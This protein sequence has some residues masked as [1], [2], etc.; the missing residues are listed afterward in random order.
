MKKP[1]TWTI[2]GSD[3][4]GGAGIQ[5]DLMTMNSLGVL[6][7]SVITALTAQNTLGIAEVEYPSQNMLAGQLGALKT[8]LPPVAVKIGML[9]HADN[10]ATIVRH[11]A[12]LD[13][14]LVCDP[15]VIA[16]SGR[17][18]LDPEALKKM[19]SSLLPLVDLLTP[20]LPEAEVLL[21]RQIT[22]AAEMESAA[23]ALLDLGVSSVL[24]KGG[25][26]PGEYCQDFWTNGSRRAWITSPK[27][28][29]THTHGTGCTLSSAIASARAL[30]F[31]ELDAI[32]IAKAYVNQGLRRGAD[33]GKGKG[34][35]AHEGWPAAPEDL[36]WITGAPAAEVARLVFPDCGADPI[37]L[38]PVVDR[39]D[40]IERLLPLG[41]RMIQLRLKDLAGAELEKEVEQAVS[42]ARR[43]DA[44][45]F[46]NDH[47]QAA[48]K[49]GAYGVH[50]GQEDLP[51]AD[52]AALSAAGLR[53]GA[54]ATSYAD[55]A[56]L[57][58]LKPSYV[59][60]GA[61]F[62]T[63]SKAIDYEPLGL[64]RFGQLSRIAG[65][66]VVA[67][68]GITLDR[69]KD[70]RDAGAGGVA[71]ISDLKSATDLPARVKAWLDVFR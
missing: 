35:L 50:L 67:I 66:P 53:L 26:L 42:I 8:D 41:V 24:L 38:Y 18:L 49:Y 5:A 22:S 44:R 21:G 68:G 39:A 37:G 14:Y 1:I 61:I 34:P 19:V 2:A 55:L 54:S 59:G 25:H 15:I 12:D 11:L 70:V 29:V 63:P 71:L 46:I 4:G 32:V 7:C 43:F 58:A 33:V 60:L 10:I 64:E 28:Q 65:M 16:T 20:N 40:W 51:G 27:Q 69:A 3:S 57:R 6:G 17:L 48:L 62:A 47:W 23:E 30:G 45:L 52:L 36:P 13:S 31:D 56:R 9:G